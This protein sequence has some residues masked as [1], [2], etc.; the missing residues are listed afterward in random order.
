MTTQYYGPSQQVRTIIAQVGEVAFDNQTMGEAVNKYDTLYRDGEF[1]RRADAS[2]IATAPVG[3]PYGLAQNA[4]GSG[5]T[6]PVWI[7]ALVSN[8]AWAFASGLPC[9]VGSGPGNAPVQS[10]PIFS[11]NVQVR[12]GWAP[13]GYLMDLNPQTGYLIAQ[14]G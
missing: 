5:G 6:I 14:S 3:G 10:A 4:A 7:R 2:A 13:T 12:L 11:G 1:W 9:F 8:G